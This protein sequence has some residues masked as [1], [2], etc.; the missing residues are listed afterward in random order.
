MGPISPPRRGIHY[1]FFKVHYLIIFNMYNFLT[2][3]NPIKYEN[4]VDKS[5]NLKVE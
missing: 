1:F 3:I 2:L 4:T 5:Q